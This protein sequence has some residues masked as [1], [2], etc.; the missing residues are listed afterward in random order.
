MRVEREQFYRPEEIASNVKAKIEKVR[1]RSEPIDYLTFV[2]DGET[3]L[4][5]NLGKE[6]DL[7]KPFGKKL[8]LLLMRL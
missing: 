8:R 4:D 2:P 5:T 1:G 3:T 7:L 6:I